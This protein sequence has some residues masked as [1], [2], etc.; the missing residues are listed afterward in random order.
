RVTIDGG[1][2][3]YPASIGS[4]VNASQEVV[5]EFQIA[6]VSL[7][8]A[9]GL[10]SSG[11][12]NIVT[13][14]GGNEFH[15]SAFAFYRDHNLAAYPALSRDVNNPDPFFQ[16]RQYGY[17][18]GGPIRRDRA[19]FFTSYER[20]DQRGAI[21]LQPRTPDFSPLGGIFASP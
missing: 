21:S 2:I 8:A 5:Q 14:S 18:L 12:I 6:T 9:T 16:R 1:S 13:R 11:A 17:F 10:T 7:D 3:M 19:F 4:M 15:G 20:S